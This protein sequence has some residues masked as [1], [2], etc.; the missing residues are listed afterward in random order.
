ML[1]RPQPYEAEA[2]THEAKAEV[3]TY[4]PETK[5]TRLSFETPKDL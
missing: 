3:K 5:F 4:A 2:L 1:T